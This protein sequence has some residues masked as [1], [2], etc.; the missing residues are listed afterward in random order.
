MVNVVHHANALAQ[1][2]QIADGGVKVIRFECP[3]VEAGSIGAIKQLD[4]ELQAAY[5]REVVLARVEEHAVEQRS[6]R[7]QS[8]RV[9]GPQ[10]AIDLDQSFLRGLYRIAPQSLADHRSHNVA[11][12]E[13][14]LNLADAG[15]HDLGKLVGGYFRVRFHQHF[16]A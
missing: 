4:V 5:A 14:H 3:A 6:C 16:T 13:E 2:E 15:F 7:I 12:R 9:A 10:L 11:L 1:L 8:W